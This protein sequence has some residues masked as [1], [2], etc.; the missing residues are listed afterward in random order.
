MKKIKEII[1]T[2]NLLSFFIIICPILDIISFLFRN[3]F[4]TNYSISTIL[5]PIIP[6][7]I[8]VYFFLKE[9]L[10]GKFKIIGVCFIYLAYALLHLYIYINNMVNCSYGTITHEAQYLINYSFM[11]VNL[12]VFTKTF[13]NKNY[14]KLQ[15]SIIISTAIYIIS[16]Y[17][18]II[19]KTSSTTYIEGMGYKGW[20][21]SG[22]SISAILVLSTFVILSFIMQISNNK[23]KICSFIVL[24]LV[25]IFLLT[26]IGTRVGLIG[27]IL[28]ILCFAMS[29][30]FCKIIGKMKINKKN[31]MVLI[32]ILVLLILIVLLAGSVTLQRRK[33]L[34]NMEDTL[35]DESTGKV[36]NIT[37]DLTNIKNKII[38]NDLEKGFMTDEQQKSV[39]DLYDIAK[40]YNISNTSIRIQQL[41]YHVML[42]KNQKNIVFILIGNGYLINTN[43]LVWEMEFPAILLNFGIIGFILYMMPILRILLKSIIIFVKNIK[44]VDT[45]FIMLILTVIL[46]FVLSTLSGYTFFNS[47]SMMII[48]VVN[49]LLKIKTQNIKRG[50]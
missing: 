35:I 14:K 37:G 24:A 47:S 5:R 39:L 23:I 1:T 30:I 32:S 46:S 28:A 17:I 10:K 13:N 31:F 33:H 19:T 18:A 7:I 29:E 49:I 4:E 6:G 34:K 40:K 45:E 22:N 8:F 25:G 27:F 9:N 48:V 26:L 16:I 21:E 43:E 41:I 42:I 44:K 2:Q 38:N 20:F 12:F 15:K 36:A 11:I 50:E 3:K